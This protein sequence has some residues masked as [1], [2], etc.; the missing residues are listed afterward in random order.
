MRMN[1]P[2]RRVLLALGA[3]LFL[4]ACGAKTDLD[5][6]P[7]SL[8]D[9]KLGYNIV[10][11]KNA[12]KVPPSRNASTE[13][14]EAKLKEALD[15]RFRRYDGDKL[16]HLGVNVDAYSLAIPGIP[17]ILAP[18][19]A[20]IISANVWDDAAQTKIH[21]EPEQLTVFEGLNGETL[22]GTGLTRRKEKQMDA[23]A[24]NA[25]QAIENW[26]LKNREAWFGETGVAAAETSVDATPEPPVN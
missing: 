15:R 10:V 7:V 11:A 13:E 16:Y 12:Q 20:L 14:W 8:G 21:E 23:L 26:L 25:A 24:A 18:K 2:G 9:F 6:P 3:A 22:I 4:T 5:A 1:L 17:I 19:S